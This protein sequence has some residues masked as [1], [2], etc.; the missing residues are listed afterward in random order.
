MGL[1]RF[2]KFILFEKV[3]NTFGYLLVWCNRMAPSNIVSALDLVK[4][5]A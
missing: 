3:L 4:S 5:I 2:E 1:G